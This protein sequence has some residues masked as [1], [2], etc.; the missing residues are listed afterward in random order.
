MLAFTS[1]TRAFHSTE[2]GQLRTEISGLM[3]RVETLGRFGLFIPA[4]VFS[5]LVSQGL[6]VTEAGACLKLPKQFLQFAWFIPLAY[7]VLSAAAAFAL[8]W[9]G[10]QMAGYLRDVEAGLAA[11]GLGWETVLEPL[12]PMLNGTITAFWVILI[13]VTGVGAAFGFVEVDQIKNFCPSSK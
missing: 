13:I 6:G 9:R 1:D 4:V 7:A 3:G 12:P 5:W 2:Y 10:R 8:Y 11:P